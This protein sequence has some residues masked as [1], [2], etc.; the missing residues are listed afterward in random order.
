MY[1]NPRSREDAETVEMIKSIPTTMRRMGWTVSA[2]LM[3]RW[4]QAPAWVLP[5]EWKEQKT[6]PTLMPSFTQMDQNTVRM[7]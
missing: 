7:S 4:L 5:I 3:E 2:Q 1:G 6:A